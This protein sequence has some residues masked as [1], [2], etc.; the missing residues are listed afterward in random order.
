MKVSSRVLFPGLLIVTRYNS[1]Y[2]K[3]SNC[4]LMVCVFFF[5]YIR[6]Q[7]RKV[8]EEKAFLLWRLG[9]KLCQVSWYRQDTG[10]VDI[11]IS[12]NSG[13]S[14]YWAQACAWHFSVGPGSL[15]V[16]S[17]WPAPREAMTVLVLLEWLPLSFAA[18]MGKGRNCC[19]PWPGHHAW[20]GKGP[21]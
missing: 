13:K 2:S 9:E 16:T 6:L 10:V 8:I 15:D 7:W 14:Q 11:I 17:R 3:V 12:V 18:I 1:L 21:R 20:V 19:Y 5:M 4:V